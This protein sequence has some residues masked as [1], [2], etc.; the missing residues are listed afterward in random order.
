MGLIFLFKR[1][2]NT[3]ILLSLGKEAKRFRPPLQL[4]TNPN[5]QN[6]SKQYVTTGGFPQCNRLT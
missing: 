5:R 3:M 4:K 6:I 2:E 1:E